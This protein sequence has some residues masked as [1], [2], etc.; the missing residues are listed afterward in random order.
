LTPHPILEEVA[1]FLRQLGA[2]PGADPAN[3]V[4][5]FVLPAFFWA[6]LAVAA[7]R[8]WRR[9]S[10]RRSLFMG[11]AALVGF[12]RELFQLATEFGSSR[13]L[14]DFQA[15]LPWYP[16]L[17]H[18]LELV[19]LVLAAYA[20][21]AHF[22]GHRGGA[23]TL[24]L[25]GL[26]ASVALYAVTAPAWHGAVSGLRALP[27]APR[28]EFAQHWGDVAFR[29][30][31]VL[32]LGATVARLLLLRA[33][34][35]ARLAAIA[36]TMFLLDHALMLVSIATGM[37]HAW[38]LS[39][40][41]HNLHIWAVPLLVGVYWGELT[42]EVRRGEERLAQ[43][44]KVRSLGL[45]TAGI[46]HDFGNLLAVVRGTLD[47]LLAEIPAGDHREAVVEARA[48][49]QRAVE[50]TGQLL[51]YAGQG[52]GLEAPVDLSA[53]AAEAARL[54]RRTL[55]PGCRLEVETTA[56][57]PTVLADA[58]RLRQVV[59]NLLLN[60]VHAM[61]G[62][63]GAITLA[64]GWGVRTLAPGLPDVTQRSPGGMVAWL[65]VADQGV[66]MS[67]ATRARIFDPFFTTRADGRGLGLSV[68]VGVVRQYRGGIAVRDVAGGGTCFRVELPATLTAP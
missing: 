31:A 40:L 59:M 44:E 42:E 52:Q 16:P 8:H 20:F 33:L 23:R 58:T 62:R 36:F 17:E 37:R 49:A 7:L 9:R 39:P 47:S 46:A 26:G 67:P 15:I 3:A 25:A 22:L 54:V 2:G 60:A 29:L 38:F 56:G 28:I 43:E 21:L 12:G 5:R 11:L 55:P 34:G 30:V 53:L 51:A 18:A 14:F 1:F 63:T 48:G 27:G 13:G 68:V 6:V 24:L 57:L 19:A 66:G 32:L 35:S 61:E 4:P 65:E 41:R 64:T 10:E 50:L 45:L